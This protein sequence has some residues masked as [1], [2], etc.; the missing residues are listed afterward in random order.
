MRFVY[1][2]QLWFSAPAIPADSRRGSKRD[3]KKPTDHGSE[4]DQQA[5]CGRPFVTKIVEAEEEIHK[6]EQKIAELEGRVVESLRKIKRPYEKFKKQYKRAATT[7]KVLAGCR[8]GVFAEKTW[9]IAMECRGNT[10]AISNSLLLTQKKAAVVQGTTTRRG[11]NVRSNP[12]MQV[13]EQLCGLFRFGL[14]ASSTK[15]DHGLRSCRKR[16]EKVS[17]TGTRKFKN[18][19]LHLMRFLCKPSVTPSH[20]IVVLESDSL[21]DASLAIHQ[22]PPHQE[23]HNGKLEPYCTYT[24]ELLMC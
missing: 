9:A 1:L 23:V 5:D 15:S 12:A 22:R 19:A 4:S 21:R 2:T 13:N 17:A 10:S 16:H 6:A 18:C 3:S 7:D 8:P 11:E 20:E 14:H 24:Q